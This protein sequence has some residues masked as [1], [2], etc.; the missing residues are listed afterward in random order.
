MIIHQYIKRGTSHE[1]FCEDY[2]FAEN[3]DDKFIVAGVFDGCSGG[4][5]SYF[6]SAFYGKA[7]KSFIKTYNLSHFN[8][9]EQVIKQILF[10]SFSNVK[11]LSEV[12]SLSSDELLS[13]VILL[14]ADLHKNI[15][16]IIC[17]GDGF[18]SVNGE[19]Y[20]I[21]QNNTPDYPAYHLSKI[22]DFEDFEHWYKNQKNIFS[23][24][25]IEDLTISTDGLFTFTD[26]KNSKNDIPKDWITN[27][28]TQD[29][30]FIK[31]KAMFGRK[32]NILKN[33]H[34]YINYDDIGIVR[35]VKE[36]I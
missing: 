10:N 11:V 17:L 13:T 2:V 18:V 32:F 14:V 34:N 7:I 6:A 26:I 24:D 22:T 25:K 20:E 9:I 30:Q 33:N 8:D 21:D 3:I 28:F 15:G 29:K 31:N 5:E 4:K 16:K 12:I 35:V 36:T 1:N 27:Y 19:N 23:F